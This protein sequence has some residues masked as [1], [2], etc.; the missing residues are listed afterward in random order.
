M[1][2]ETGDDEMIESVNVCAKLYS[3]VRQINEGSYNGFSYNGFSY[4]GFSY[5]GISCK[6]KKESKKY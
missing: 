5:N 1:K 2:H 4:N 6:G 3:H